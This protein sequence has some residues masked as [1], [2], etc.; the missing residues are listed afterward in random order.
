MV[1]QRNIEATL[2]LLALLSFSIPRDVES[3][4]IVPVPKK[5]YPLRVNQLIGLKAENRDGQT[6]GRLR[7]FVIDLPSGEVKLVLFSSGGYLG[8]G[9]KWK[10]VPPEMVSA[11]TAKRDVLAVETTRSEWSKRPNFKPSRG[12]D[13]SR[14]R[15]A[16]EL[17][18]KSVVDRDQVKLGEILDLLV[19][20][21]ERA[22]GFAIFS[23][24]K[25]FRDGNHEFAIPL[26]AIQLTSSGRVMVNA[27]RQTLEHA[28]AMNAD[29]WK[30]LRAGGER[31]EIFR[32]SERDPFSTNGALSSGKT[33]ATNKP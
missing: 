18:G 17:I 9:T 29:A 31:Q 12:S 6:L 21:N 26:R 3:A 23:A 7:D 25:L 8:I 13:A 32:Y 16:S 2:L 14:P 5:F 10:A 27:D 4:D 19:T 1:I 28:R 11:A 30:T 22:P 24:G 20:F 15:L 33:L